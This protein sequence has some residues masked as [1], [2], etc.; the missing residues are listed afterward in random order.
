V[1]AAAIALVL[2][3]ATTGGVPEPPSP[4]TART[5]E[6][7]KPSLLTVEVHSGNREAKSSLG[8]GYVAAPGL[9]VTNYHVVSSLVSEPERYEIRLRT[10]VGDVPARVKA[11]DVENDLALLDAPGVKSAALPLAQ[12][13]PPP[14]SPIV[15]LGN[16]HGLGLSLIEGIFNGF[17]AKGAVDRMLLSMPLNSGMSGGPILDGQGRVI[18]TNVSVLYDSDSLSFGVPVSKVGPLLAAPAVALDRASLQAELTRQLSALEASMVKRVVAAYVEPGTET[19]RVG[20]A[21]TH[22]PPDVFECWDDTEVHEQQGLTKSRLGCDLQ[23]TPT[24]GDLGPVGSISLLVEHFRT[25][26][27]RYGFYSHLEGHGGA[28]LEVGPH[29]PEEGTFSAPQCV[30]DRVAAGAQVWKT[31]ACVSALVDHPGFFNF[32]LAATTVT[33]PRAAAFVAV[34]MQGVRPASFRAFTERALSSTRLVED[35][36]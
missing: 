25:A 6:R 17:A 33:D 16:P 5:F 22:R 14:G 26:R 29:A 32:D 23:F 13:L 7:V 9:V 36:R 12:A 24:I 21:E 11:F 31:N 10:A 15:A 4:A 3:A 18:G 30:S 20:G 2:Q 19:A 8:S 1:L 27:G 35:A 34:H 28:H